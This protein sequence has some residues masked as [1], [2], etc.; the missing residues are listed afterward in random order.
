M[1]QTTD[2]TKLSSNPL[3]HEKKQHLE[4]EILSTLKFYEQKIAIMT[5][6]IEEMNTT[7][8]VIAGRIL[9]CLYIQRFTISLIDIEIFSQFIIIPEEL[10]KVCLLFLFLF[11]SFK[12]HTQILMTEI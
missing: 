8:R 6:A 9:S 12:M 10:T 7:E 3:S 5:L 2:Y 11:Y 4:Q 1:Y